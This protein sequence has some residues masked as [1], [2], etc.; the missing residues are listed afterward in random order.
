MNAEMLRAIQQRS[1]RAAIGS[2][3]M[4]GAGSK[5]VVEAGREFLSR[6]NLAPFGTS[7][8]RRFAAHLDRTTD[9]LQGHLPRSARHWGL[10]RKGLNI[11]LRDCLY[12]AYLRK[13]YRL[14][15]AERFF[16]VPLD[17]ICGDRLYDAA[18]DQL[19]KWPGVRKLDP[20]T[21]AR[22]QEV[23]SSVARKRG[24]ARVHLDALWWGVRSIN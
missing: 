4:R 20:E 23:A 15:V 19:P 1:A 10:A 7:D 24:A 11:F 2:S 17:S 8:S 3:A 5:G 9:R 16:E 14:N 18:K 13:H 6:L 12:T 21:S 22:Y